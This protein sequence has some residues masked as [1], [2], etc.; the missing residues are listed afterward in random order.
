M[1][2][3]TNLDVELTG[4]FQV[5]SAFDDPRASVVLVLYLARRTGSR[6]DLAC[7]DDANDA[8]FFHIDNI[9]PDI[10]FQAHR[11]ALKQVKRYIRTQLNR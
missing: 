2:E 4:L 1:K 3:E 7:G 6:E 5:I 10:A 8:R 11:D 9:P